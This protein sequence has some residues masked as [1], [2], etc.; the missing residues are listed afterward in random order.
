M[1][2][3]FDVDGDLVLCNNNG[4]LMT[5]LSIEH[6]IEEWCLFIAS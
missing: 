1:L 3:F 6:K 5:E 4:L 2:K